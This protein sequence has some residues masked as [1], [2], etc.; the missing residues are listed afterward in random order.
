MKTRNQIE[1][2]YKWDLTILCPSDEEFYKAVEK[3]KDW[4]LKFKQFEN[5]LKDKETI[6][7]YLKLDEEFEKFISPYSLY[8]HLKQNEILSDNS[9]NEMVETLSQRFNEFSIE[10]SFISSE[11][12]LL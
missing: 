8:A 4:T 11:I 1:D 2:K 10:T 3:I 12:H 5:K 7:Q 9:R 6:L